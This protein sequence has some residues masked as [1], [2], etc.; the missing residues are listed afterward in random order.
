MPL[1]VDDTS[2]DPF[3]T[4]QQQR[5]C[6]GTGVPRA[7]TKASAEVHESPLPTTLGL[8]LQ[9]APHSA[10]SSITIPLPQETH[11]PASNKRSL[12]RYQGPLAKE[13]DTRLAHPEGHGLS[14]GTS[15]LPVA[16]DGPPSSTLPTGAVVVSSS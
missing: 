2:K 14:G 8:T 15:V 4:Q 5:H 16:V 11:S 3:A 7:D 1:A 12:D 13:S 6:L 9:E 10:T